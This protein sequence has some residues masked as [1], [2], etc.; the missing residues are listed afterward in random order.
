VRAPLARAQ[1]TVPA[2]AVRS[3]RRHGRGQRACRLTIATTLLW[4][5]V[6]TIPTL[7]LVRQLAGVMQEYTQ[8]G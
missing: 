6:Q 1:P 8:R 4:W 5:L 3:I 7:Q 2:G